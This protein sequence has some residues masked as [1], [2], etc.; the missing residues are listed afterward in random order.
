MQLVNENI[1]FLFGAYTSNE[2][3]KS[4]NFLTDTEA[5]IYKT[6]DG[7]SQWNRTVIGKGR[8]GDAYIIDNVIYAIKDSFTENSFNNTIRKI[9]SSS[10]Y[11]NSWNELTNPSWEIKEIADNSSKRTA[12]FN[13][14]LFIIPLSMDRLLK[15]DISTK[16]REVVNL[17]DKFKPE[18]ILNCN[19]TLWVLGY[20]RNK[21][22]IY[23]FSDTENYSKVRF[24]IRTSNAPLIKGFH[25]FNS[26]ISLIIADEASILGATHRFFFSKNLGQTWIEEPLAEK[27][28]VN[29]IAFWRSDNVW[30]YIGSGQ[31]QIRR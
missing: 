18:I 5:T 16:K 3:Y 15:V 25:V 2:A 6:S 28:Y 27:M 8:F 4:K 26:Q 29:P 14:E 23:Y 20:N 30:T 21:L 12:M 1:G 7:G 10:D 9:Y 13:N 31:I 22:E 24:D 19:D 17:P 11:G